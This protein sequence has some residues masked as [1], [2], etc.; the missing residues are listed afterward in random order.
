[1]SAALV[2][3]L[4]FDDQTPPS[5]DSSP[6]LRNLDLTLYDVTGGAKNLIATSSSLIDNT[7]N[8]WLTLQPARD[9]QIEVRRGTGQ[10]AFAGRYAFAWN[11]RVSGDVDSDGDTVFNSSDNCTQIANSGQQDTDGDGYGNRC[12]ADLNNDDTVNNLDIVLF[13]QVFLTANAH[14]DFNSDGAVNSLDLAILKS[15]YLKPPGPGAA[16]GP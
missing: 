7:E 12:D 2:W 5:F 16:T 3:L 14:A 6:A 9:Y 11:A 4:E 13:K 8:L 15:L 10:A 1:L